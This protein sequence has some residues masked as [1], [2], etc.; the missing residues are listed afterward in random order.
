MSESVIPR[1]YFV[2]ISHW[3][4]IIDWEKVK[5]FDNGSIKFVITKATDSYGGKM[6]TDSR[7]I[8]N[9]KGAKSVD[10]PIGVYHWLKCDVAPK[11][12]SQYIVDV[13]GKYDPIMYVVDIEERNIVSATDYAWRAQEWTY[14]I[15]QST[16]KKP[17]I[18][19]A[20]WYISAYL[21]TPLKSQKKDYEKIIGWMGNYDLWVAGYPSSKY[22]ILGQLTTPKIPQEWNDYTMWQFASNVYY[23]YPGVSEWENK[24]YG[25]GRDIFG[26]SG[27]KGFDMNVFHIDF[28]ELIHKDDVLQDDDPEG[29]YIELEDFKTKLLETQK[30][31]NE[32]KEKIQKIKE[33]VE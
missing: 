5:A 3:T 13:V 9:I 25:D 29:D 33:I 12:A 23:P 28:E 7:A 15:E 26:A 19:T 10:M 21:R 2:D 20:E 31:L 6:F 4:G 22:N 17:K 8:E 16:H 30:S 1:Y 24:V 11:T 32:V 27:S 14:L 18:Y